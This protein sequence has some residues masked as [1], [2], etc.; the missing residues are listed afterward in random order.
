MSKRKPSSLGIGSRKTPRNLSKSSLGEELFREVRERVL[1]QYGPE[2]VLDAD[3]DYFAKYRS[4]CKGVK[5]SLAAI[6]YEEFLGFL[7]VEHALGFRGG[8]SITSEGNETQL[9]V[10][11]LIGQILQERMPRLPCDLP[12]L[13]LEF[14]AHLGPGDR[15]LTFNYDTLLEQALTAVGKPF[16]LFPNRFESVDPRHG[17]GVLDNSLEEVVVLKLHGS[18]DWFD[19]APYEEVMAAVGDPKYVPKWYPHFADSNPYALAPL[20]EGLQMPDDPMLRIH[21]MRNLS[22]YYSQ[23]FVPQPPFVLTPSA[24]KILYFE[25][26]KPLWGGIGGAGGLNLGMAII[27]YSLPPHDAHARQ[28]IYRLTDNYTHFEPD[29]E[30]G[31]VKKLP[32]RIVNLAHNDSDVSEFRSRYGFIDWS[33]TETSLD[34][35]GDAAIE[36]IF[37]ERA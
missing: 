11:K 13:Y 1:A 2:N 3:L 35:F 30:I 23:P 34:G 33:R 12:S 28:A 36:F 16:R 24:S 4:T 25:L 26:L 29:L 9:I 22:A 7:D 27:G 10:K 8:D 17:Y 18:V 37:G 31:G 6:D 15:V 20:L 21:R 5:P 32:L 19:R 14:A